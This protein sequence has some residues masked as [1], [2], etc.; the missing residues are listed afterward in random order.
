[1][2]IVT[3]IGARPQFI[4]AAAVSGKLKEVGIKERIIHTG[5]HFDTT[6][7][8][9]FFRELQIPDPVYNL[10]IAAKRH[11]E[12]I[13]GMLVK[14]EEILIEEAPLAVM[15]YGDTNSTLAGALAACKLNIDVIHIEAGLRSYKK[16]MPEEVNRILT[17]QMSALL[18][19]P[20]IKAKENLH[21]EGIT[22]NV[23]VCGDVMGDLFFSC[24][25]RA[26]NKQ[27]DILCSAGIGSEPFSVLTC[28]RDGATH[29]P[30]IIKDILSA[31]NQL[32]V[33][34]VFPVHPRT[35]NLIRD[36]GI[37]L[38]E[39]VKELSPLGYLNMIAL[40]H[41]AQF[42]MTDS[43]GMQKEAYWMGKPC[44]TLREETEWVETVQNG[45][46]VLTGTNSARILQSVQ[47]YQKPQYRPPLYGHGS[48][49]TECAK[50]IVEYLERN[51][52]L[53]G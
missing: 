16:S 21:S 1:M 3:V 5:Q 48:A 2:K 9:V 19:C 11:G 34:V 47:S 13:A 40:M 37:K 42:I 52:A 12:M 7:S 27:S 22:E 24:L 15:V 14:I 28:H 18:L 29:S 31:V 38:P 36:N 10:G 32:G 33:K 46:N 43:G 39:N 17:D 51:P 30:Q 26:K 44:F 49:G 35:K 6:M 4:K 41:R 45:W 23:Y 50:L 53:Q 25:E 20:S 8:E